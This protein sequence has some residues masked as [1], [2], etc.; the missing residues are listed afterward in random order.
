LLH[1]RPTWVGSMFI[2]QGV[3]FGL[4]STLAALHGIQ[5]PDGAS[6]QLLQQL[7]PQLLQQLTQPLLLLSNTRSTHSYARMGHPIL[8]GH[9]LPAAPVVPLAP[10]Q[11][12]PLLATA[13][14]VLHRDRLRCCTCASFMLPCELVVTLLMV[15]QPLWQWCQRVSGYCWSR[16][17]QHRHTAGFGLHR[18]K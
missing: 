12:A 1:N 9:C 8:E 2:V 16:A 6:L 18:C 3:N 11:Q 14:T 15:L 17:K 7:A 5:C 4:S 13:T 10:M